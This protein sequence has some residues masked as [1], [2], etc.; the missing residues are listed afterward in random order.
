M[1]APLIWIG[2]P[3]VF[4][5]ATL[6]LGRGSKVTA[7]L[8]AGFCGLLA[9]LA[10][11]FPV[12]ETINLGPLSFELSSTLVIL[13]RRFTINPGDRSFLM[14]LYL[15]G[16]LWFLGALVVRM[17]HSFAPLGLSIIAL[18]VAALAVEPFLYAALLI[19]TAVLLSVP[20]LVPP[21]K[22]P[23]TGV[24]RYVIFQT[25]AMPFLL[26]AGWAAAAVQANPANDALLQQAVLLLG[27]GF[28]FWLAVFP[29]YTW[30]PLLVEETN[31]YAAGFLL[32]LLPM[33]VLMFMLNFFGSYPWL[34]LYPLA[35]Q[36]LQLV[37]ILM[38]VTG[39][40]WAAFQ[41]NL[42][43]LFSYAV[44]IENGFALLALSFN[45]QAGYE[46]FAASFLPRA[47]AL[48]LFAM[49]LALLVEREGSRDFEETTGLLHRFPLIASGILLACF[50][51]AGLPLMAGF[52]VR[53][54][55]LEQLSQQSILLV[56]WALVGSAGLILCAF[57]RPGCHGRRPRR[58]LEAAR[59]QGRGVF[60]GRGDARGGAD[61]L[62][63]RAVPAR[64]GAA[65][66]SFST[67][68]LSAKF[69]ILLMLVDFE[70]N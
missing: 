68:V 25:L 28:A 1:S 10:G 12:A 32:S 41:T 43:R 19:E 47:V 24:M 17:H 45:N 69:V 26:V 21:G 60:P 62:A 36:A 54:V 16:A 8:S 3:L 44:I 63:A 5:I 15:F 64:A 22:S 48:A 39:G 18:M 33:I 31:P 51:L 61:R 49:A 50:S 37:G 42:A 53:I 59:E 20:M 11:V 70:I 52:P 6:M 46:I 14:L 58:V 27:L 29:F 38:V 9:L 66:A 23:G 55:L 35:T 40:I 67:P 65:A 2:L 13:G 57:P 30:M 7:G 4:A 56:V 34:R